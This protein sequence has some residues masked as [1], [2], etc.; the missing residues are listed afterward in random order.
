MSQEGFG[1]LFILGRQRSPGRRE[2]G[3]THCTQQL[4]WGGLNI[5]HSSVKGFLHPKKKR[6]A[7]KH[8]SK[9]EMLSDISN[10]NRFP[11]AHPH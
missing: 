6:G 8:P 10:R 5:S 1:G 9:R 11:C 2:P 4:S 3:R 7:Q